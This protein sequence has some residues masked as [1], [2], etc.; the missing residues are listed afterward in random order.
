MRT[1]CAWRYLPDVFPP[2]QTVYSYFRVWRIGRVWERLNT[3]LRAQVRMAMDRDPQP[4]AGILDSQSVKTTEQG[5]VSGYDGGKKVKGRKR[6]IL[7]DTNGLLLEVKVL[8]ANITDRAGGEALLP[9]AKPSLPRLKHL[10]V[11]GGY[12]GKWV[13]WVKQTLKWSLDVVQ[14]PDANTRGY[15]LPEGKE[16]T[17]EQI[18]TFR[19]NREFMV[20]PRRWVVERTFAWTSRNRR[21]AKDY[22]RLPETGEALMYAAIVRLMLTRLANTNSAC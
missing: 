15:W 22:E 18:K 6:H 14:R 13:A 12:I 20:I 16:L 9:L 1:G 4:S 5:G 17:P 8:A 21:L 10:F 7:V 11:D 3:V 2:W 19:G